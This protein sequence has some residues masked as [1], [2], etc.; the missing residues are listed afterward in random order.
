MAG[1]SALYEVVRTAVDTDAD[2]AALWADIG[3]QRREGARQVVALLTAADALTPRLTPERAA[4][5]ITV[6]ND[7]GLHRHLVGDRDWTYED[8]RDW[9]ARALHH[10]LLTPRQ[11]S[12]P[13]QVS[14]PSASRQP[15]VRRRRG[16]RAGPLRGFERSVPVRVTRSGDTLG[17]GDPRW[18]GSVRPWPPL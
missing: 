6:C 1:V 14:Q 5:V 3:L 9:L 4:D 10:E 8:F 15:A 17:R 7:P 18:S 16:L 2:V 13:G 11:K 12:P